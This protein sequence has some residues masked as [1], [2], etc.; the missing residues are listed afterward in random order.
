MLRTFWYKNG[1]PT[2]TLR[3]GSRTLKVETTWRS[4]ALK[5]HPYFEN[6]VLDSRIHCLLFHSIRPKF[7]GACIGFAR[8]RETPKGASRAHRQ[9]RTEH[10]LEGFSLWTDSLRQ[11]S[12]Q[13]QENTSRFSGARCIGEGQIIS[14]RRGLLRGCR[15]NLDTSR[16]SGR[17]R[18]SSSP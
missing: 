14:V 13:A 15:A 1:V 4:L 12:A 5:N 18:N 3:K 11:L 2:T 10:L 16:V 17:T 9:R 6:V 8:A 7:R